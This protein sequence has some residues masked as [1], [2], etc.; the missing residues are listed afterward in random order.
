M[1]FLKE[2]QG[3]QEWDV[4]DQVLGW[5]PREIRALL[6]SNGLLLDMWEKLRTDRVVV[7]DTSLAAGNT[8]A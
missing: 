4:L 6:E 2:A 7:S 3:L 8:A 5:E 1:A